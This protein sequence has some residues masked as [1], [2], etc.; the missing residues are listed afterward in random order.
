[1]IA[2][3]LRPPL[4]RT[5]LLFFMV[6][7]K[8][9]RRVQSELVGENSQDNRTMHER[10]IPSFSDTV[11]Q[12]RYHLLPNTNGTLPSFFV[13]KNVARGTTSLACAVFEIRAT[14]QPSYSLTVKSTVVQLQSIKLTT[15]SYVTVPIHLFATNTAFVWKDL[16][17]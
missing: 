7:E 15:Y 2:C 4:L 3:R 11:A 14:S 8:Q 13:F 10:I 16:L 17:E 1:M 12:Q 6:N 5:S 9:T